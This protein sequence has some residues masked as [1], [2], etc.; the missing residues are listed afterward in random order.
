VK[1]WD[2]IQGYRFLG[3]ALIDVEQVIADN[4]GEVPTQI[5]VWALR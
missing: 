5:E 1:L 3:H 4:W 2:Y